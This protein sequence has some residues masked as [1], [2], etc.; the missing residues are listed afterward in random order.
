MVRTQGN[1]ISR[2]GWLAVFGGWSI[3]C[4]AGE[5]PLNGEENSP[6]QSGRLGQP[7]SAVAATLET[8]PDHG[9]AVSDE[10]DEELTIDAALRVWCRGST[11]P[12]HY[13]FERYIYDSTFCNERRAQGEV[14]RLSPTR[15]R[16][17][18]EPSTKLP[19]QDSN[20]RRW[21]SR[22]TSSAGFPIEVESDEPSR[23][24]RI[25]QEGY[26][27]DLSAAAYDRMA[28]PDTIART[29]EAPPAVTET[30]FWESLVS[31]FRFNFAIL[32]TGQLHPALIGIPQ[33]PALLR[34]R[35]S[36]TAGE[37][38][39]PP[40]PSGTWTTH[41]ILVPRFAH[42]AEQYS[43][44]EVLIMMPE[45]RC[46]ALKMTDPKGNRE[47]VYVF[48]A[49]GEA[50]SDH[51][52]CATALRFETWCRTAHAMPL[53]LIGDYT[54]DGQSMTNGQVT[55]NRSDSLSHA[56]QAL[57]NEPGAERAVIVLIDRDWVL[58]GNAATTESA[59]ALVE[60]V[61]RQRRP[62]SIREVRSELVIDD[63]PAEDEA[64]ESESDVAR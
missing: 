14:W 47:T 15:W 18:I 63:P 46:R 7:A 57:A 36:I 10:I 41:L 28:I 24:V 62:I 39:T 11:E 51:A 42:E 21:N 17:D 33:D 22:K 40:D 45:G 49:D 52:V 26:L 31:G 12:A 60:F 32:W 54:A 9:S 13:R 59:D 64:G 34:E 19:E 29:D 43:R 37:R 50:S 27:C 44:A 20:G 1:R 61:R 8:G 38:N 2:L 55:A 35:H 6:L 4:V 25:D 3:A 5:G 30:G 58:M 23:W 48:R 56:H 16:L 53:K